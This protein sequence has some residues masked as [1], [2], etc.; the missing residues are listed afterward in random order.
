MCVP[1]Y[2]TVSMMELRRRGHIYATGSRPE[3]VNWLTASLAI[4][5][6]HTIP[7][8]GD[9]QG[10]D[11]PWHHTILSPTPNSARTAGRNFV[12]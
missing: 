7:D 10:C 3:G 11:A 2:R 12:D 8:T 4:R 1:G 6:I 9:V 5:P